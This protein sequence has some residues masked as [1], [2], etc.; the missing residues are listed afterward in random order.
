MNTIHSKVAGVIKTNRDGSS[1][2]EIINELSE[3]DIL[4]LEREPNNTYDQNAI[5]VLTDDRR[6]IGYLTKELAAKLA[7]L[8][9]A[10]QEIECDLKEITGLDQDAQGVNIE[11]TVYTLEET[12]ELYERIQQRIQQR[13]AAK[14]TSKP[15]KPQT[16]YMVERS[17]K[18]FWVLVIYWVFLG[19]FGGHRYY[20][21]RGSLLYTIT[22]GYFMIGWI[23]DGFAIFTG[24]F[25]DGRGIEIKP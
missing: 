18:N 9:D 25:K 21:G 8:M 13:A 20:A 14:K 2:Q 16:V 5:K 24:L 12:R 22:I 11:L 6:Q 17:N 10:G 3:Y 19:M 7:P 15:T 23:I 1:R 4:T